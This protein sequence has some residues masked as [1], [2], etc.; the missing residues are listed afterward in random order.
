MVVHK[1]GGTSVGDLARIRAVADRIHRAVRAGDRVA[2]V[3]SAMAGETDRLLGLARDM[4]A[5]ERDREVDALLATGEQASAA[6][7]SMALRNRGLD[8]TSLTGWQAGLETDPSHGRAR[9]TRF[10]AD[11]VR[12]VL[13][14]AGIPVVSGFQGVSPVADVT[15]LGRGGS[16]TTAV[17]LAVALGADECI[18]GT[19]VDGVYTADPRIVPLAGRLARISFEEMMELAGLGSKVLAA[20]SVAFAGR[21]RVPLRVVSAFRESEGTLISY[22]ETGMEAPRIVGITHS[23]DETLISLRG[24][25][26]GQ[27]NVWRVLDAVA[28]AG[29]EIDMLAQQNAPGGGTDLSFTA[30][31]S[32]YEQSVP[33]L[34]EL[35]GVLGVR[36]VCHERGLAKISLVGVGVRRA[37]A[38]VAAQLCRTLDE[39]GIAVRQMASS[40][41]KI[42]VAVESIFGEQAVRALHRAFGLDEVR[43]TVVAE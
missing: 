7:L 12:R 13:D 42:S 15:T 35:R 20:R 40:E 14:D 4:E 11:R 18:I 8:A 30:H 2:V 26:S 28:A 29:I 22:E 32:D 3:V 23:A 5:P 9:I 24:I 36:E 33:L 43:G 21:Y 27:G 37:H 10:G 41:I 38:R 25:P 17:A 1:Y 34:R 6:L 31:G 19:D 39:S 16:D